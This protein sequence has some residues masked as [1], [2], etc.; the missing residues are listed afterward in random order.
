MKNMKLLLAFTVT[1]MLFF[2]SSFA[3]T[4]TRKGGGGNTIVSCAVFQAGF[5]A[6]YYAFGLSASDVTKTTPLTAPT[7]VYFADEAS[8]RFNGILGTNLVDI[9]TN[10]SAPTS[11]SKVVT[12]GSSAPYIVQVNAWRIGYDI[13]FSVIRS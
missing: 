3:T 1:A 11:F 6:P 12:V 9:S 8:V 2:S 13:Y 7:I 10:P 4:I 5:G